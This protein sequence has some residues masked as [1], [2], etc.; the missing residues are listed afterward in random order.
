MVIFHY[1]TRYNSLIYEYYILI[2]LI[3]IT[4]NYNL[5][6]EVHFNLYIDYFFHLPLMKTFIHIEQKVKSYYINL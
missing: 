6:W 1:M 2:Y 3:N 4:D 5:N